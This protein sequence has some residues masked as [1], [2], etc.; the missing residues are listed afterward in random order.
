MRIIDPEI[1]RNDRIG[2]IQQFH[3]LNETESD[4]ETDFQDLSG[5]DDPEADRDLMHGSGT[6]P[7]PVFPREG[8]SPDQDSD[9]PSDQG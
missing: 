3:I 9:R 7:S 6:S 2:L 8:R 5:P 4:V 1:V